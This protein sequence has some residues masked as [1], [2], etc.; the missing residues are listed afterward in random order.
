MIG[1]IST[2]VTWATRK[3]NDVGKYSLQD[4]YSDLIL[5][6]FTE[7]DLEC[8]ANY[9]TEEITNVPKKRTVQM[10]ELKHDVYIIVEFV[11]NEN[12][13]KIQTVLWHYYWN[14]VKWRKRPSK[15]FS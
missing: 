7:T 12:S 8:N 3:W 1:Y 15:L 11:L 13:K 10:G 5:S 9:D 2:G 6:E 4:S 14:D